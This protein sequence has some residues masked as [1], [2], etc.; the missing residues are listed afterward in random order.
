MEAVVIQKIQ[1]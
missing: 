1:Y